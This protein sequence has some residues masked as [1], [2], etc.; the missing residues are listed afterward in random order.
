VSRLLA[1]LLIAAACAVDEPTYDLDAYP[2]AAEWRE[3]AAAIHDGILTAT[4]LARIPPQPPPRHAIHSTRRFDGYVVENVWFESLPGVYVTGNLYRPSGRGDGPFPVVL[5]PHGHFEVAGYAP[6]TRPE[7]QARLVTL[8]RMG[9]VAFTWDMPGFGES[10]Q[11][12]HFEPVVPSL[13]L[14]NS[15]RAIDLVASLPY[16]D[17]AR[18]AVSGASGGGTQ[19]FLL[20]AVEP[21]RIAASAPVV[22]VSAR[23]AGGC[24]CEALHGVYVAGTRVN[25]MEIAAAAAPRPQLIV[26]DGADWTA[27]VPDEEMPF[28]AGVYRLFDAEDA[29]INLHLADEGH[30]YGRSKREAAYDFFAERLGLERVEE[31][32]PPILA[33]DELR[34]FDAAHPRPA[35]ALVG[36]AAIALALRRLER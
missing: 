3:H 1:I 16:V 33:H 25:N 17:P 5:S 10:M 18:I 19:S 32:D 24:T 9:A 34:A 26:S 22:M 29:V 21:E 12:S 2:T 30:D 13:L 20:A 23:Y 11:V 14:W 8:A 27:T 36:S 15:I 28:I 7:M 35:D 4:R 31:G 6:R